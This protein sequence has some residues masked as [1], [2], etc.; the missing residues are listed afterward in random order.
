MFFYFCRYLDDQTP[1]VQLS[2]YFTPL[3]MVLKLNVSLTIVGDGLL[4]SVSALARGGG[5]GRE[6]DPH[7]KGASD[8]ADRGVELHGSTQELQAYS[9]G[10]A[11]HL[12]KM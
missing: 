4:L 9:L 8:Q 11:H 12:V 6:I 1:I 2:L 5:G 7:L 10:E 3:A